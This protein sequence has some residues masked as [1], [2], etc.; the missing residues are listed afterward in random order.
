METVAYQFKS[1][2]AAAERA[3]VA[4]RWRAGQARRACVRPAARAGRAARAHGDAHR[5]VRSRLAGPHRRGPQ[6]AGAGARAAQGARAEGD[7]DGS[8]PRL[9]LRVPLDDG[10]AHRCRAGDGGAPQH[11]PPAA[12]RR[13]DA[14]APT[15]GGAADQPAGR[16]ADATRPR[17]RHRGRLHACSASIGSSRWPAPAAS[18]RRASRRRSRISCARASRRRVDRRAGAARRRPRADL[19]ALPCARSASSPDAAMPT[20]DGAA[21]AL[22]SL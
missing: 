4:G 2:P 21:R 11:R 16:S 18:A 17:R 3:A 12:S 13:R 1:L 22:S 7:R 5:A 8:G 15:C 14:A 20:P 6:P 9:S 10:A 19:L